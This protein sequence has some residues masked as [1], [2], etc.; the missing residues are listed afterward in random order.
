M[1][2]LLG[3]MVIFGHV[4]NSDAAAPAS[5]LSCYQ[6]VRNKH[7]E[8]DPAELLPCASKFDRCVTHI[9]KDEDGFKIERQCGIGPCTFNDLMME[10]TIGIGPDSCDRSRHNYF[11]LFCCRESGCNK[12]SSHKSCLSISISSTLFFVLFFY[13]I[14]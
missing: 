14:L 13:T 5:N 6:C 12:N 11:C 8:C 1:S 2:Y 7:E 3:L 10:K 9:M 4:D